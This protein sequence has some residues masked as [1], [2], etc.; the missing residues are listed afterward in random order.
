MVSDFVL[1]IS[2]LFGD[3]KKEIRFSQSAADEKVK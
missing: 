3:R 2:N 1:R